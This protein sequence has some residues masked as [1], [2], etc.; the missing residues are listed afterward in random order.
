ML[1]L[2]PSF[3]RKEKLGIFERYVPIS[4]PIGLGF[5]IGYLY[6][7][8]KSVQFFDE[9]IS[10]F[11]EE[12]LD[13]YVKKMSKPYI[14]G[15]CCF[16]ASFARGLEL[17]KMIKNK[18]PDTVIIMGGIH[19]TVLPEETLKTE[20]VDIVVRGEGEIAVNLLYDAIKEK[21]NLSAI[22]GI[23]Y[24]DEVGKLI[25]NPD[26]E[27]IQNLDILPLFPYHIF[28]ELQNKYNLSFLVTARGCPY[29]CIFCSQRLVS[30]K[31]Y[32][33]TSPERAVE[34]LGILINK[35]NQK[36]VGFLDDNF[37][38]NRNRTK[39]ICELIIKNGF[40]KKATFSCQTRGDAL[41]DEI[42]KYLKEAGFA[43]IGIGLETGSERLMKLID[44][45]E[46]VKE[47]IEGVTLAKKYGFRVSGAF[48]IGLPTETKE[49]RMQAFLLAKSLNIDNVRFNNA[50]PYPGTKLYDMVLKE[51]R[52]NA[53]ENWKNL[54]T[55]GTL[56]EGPFAK[57]E[58]AYVPTT[59]TK[60]ELKKDILKMN[61]HFWLR[62]SRILRII[63][64]GMVVDWFVLPRLWYLKPKEWYYLSALSFKVLLTLIK[65]VLLVK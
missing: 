19:P 1:L 7:Q 42:L 36:F 17:S 34:D 14:I 49:E 58:M 51:N 18:Y 37:I 26:V 6:Q 28:D 29:N 50:T 23:S 16:T 2:N 64:S 63:F 54:S 57:H 4:V 27:L 31:S 30:G 46:T 48:I 12:K 65:K 10:P 22:R 43:E 61:L 59:C 35:Y 62:P 13:E 3:S 53:G 9:Q 11:T 24:K 32:R 8:G 55:C 20:F 56:V 40:N 44:K 21:R 47:N 5:L 45:G 39:R 38:V 52:L 15:L 33:Y 60:E 25:H 41:D